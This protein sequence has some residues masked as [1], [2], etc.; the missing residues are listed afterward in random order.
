MALEGAGPDGWDEDAVGTLGTTD[1]EKHVLP[2]GL[3][4]S[5]GELTVTGSGD[6]GPVGIGTGPTLEA[7]SPD[8]CSASPCCSW[9]R[10]VSGPVG[11]PTPRRS[12]RTRAARSSPGPSSSVA[13]PSRSDSSPRRSS[14]S[15]DRLFCVPA[16]PRSRRSVSVPGW[17]SSSAPRAAR[18]RGRLRVRARGPATA[19]VG[20]TGGRDRDLGP[21]AVL[22]IVPLLPDSVAQ[23]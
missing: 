17:P 13:P 3:V 22:S 5:D 11:N 1:W 21:P 12:R 7:L 6:I 2:A 9:S 4:E 20:G 15:L 8:S 10:P 14:S 16:E 23:G 19:E 18:R